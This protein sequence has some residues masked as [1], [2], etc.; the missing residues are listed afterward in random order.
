MF[1]TQEHLRNPKLREDFIGI[2]IH[3]LTH[4]AYTIKQNEKQ[5]FGRYEELL[6]GKNATS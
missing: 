5:V 4:C 2:L 3:E 6:D 1:F